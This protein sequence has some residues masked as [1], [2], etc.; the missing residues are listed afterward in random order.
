M[1]ASVL[2]SDVLIYVPAIIMVFRY[3]YASQLRTDDFFLK[4]SCA[5]SQPALLLI[6]H[7]HFQ[8]N[9]IM[10]ALTAWSILAIHQKRYYTAS[11][12]FCLALSF[13]QMALFYAPAF[14]FFLLGKSI[15]HVKDDDNGMGKGKNRQRYHSV[16]SAIKQLSFLAITVI[17]SFSLVFFPYIFN[18]SAL[19]Q[20]FLRIFP[21]QRGLYEDKVA[22]VWCTLSS[23]GLKLRGWLDQNSLVKLSAILTA[24][25]FLPA[26]LSIL[27]RPSTHKFLYVLAISSLSFFLFGFQ[28][29]EKSILL[30]CLPITLLYPVDPVF[31][32]W[33]LSVSLYR[34][35][36]I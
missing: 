6:D 17:T 5:L 14:F 27:M 8:Y 1:R 10:L 31:C 24:L 22:N 12:L 32:H 30:P 7:G 26:C 21:F 16:I 3:F 18:P 13:K 29:H 34:Y 36:D 33:F 2:A 28:V 15:S 11:V 4:I 9:H 20:V 19:S 25:A 35:F 23:F